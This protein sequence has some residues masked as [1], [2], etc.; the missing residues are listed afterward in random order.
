M[1]NNKGGCLW[2]RDAEMVDAEDHYKDLI[3]KK[4]RKIRKIKEKRLKSNCGYGFVAF[5]SNLQVKRLQHE[6]KSLIKDKVPQ[7]LKERAELKKWKVK[8]APVISDIIWKNMMNDETVASFKSWILMIILFVVCVF[9]I[10]PT[11]LL[12]NY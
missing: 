11:S 1:I 6:F 4:S 8:K 12:D 2:C 10:T 5:S 3:I 9:I 7:D